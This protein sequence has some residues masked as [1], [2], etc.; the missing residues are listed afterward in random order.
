MHHNNLNNEAYL[1]KFI[2]IIIDFVDYVD[3]ILH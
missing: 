2:I 1:D 3:K